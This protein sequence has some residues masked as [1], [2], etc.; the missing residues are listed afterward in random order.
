MVN[1]CYC[2]NFPELP[3]KGNYEPNMY[4]LYM[5]DT[6]LL[7]AMLDEEEQEDLRENKN[8][9]TYKGAIYENMIG[10]ALVKQGF[11]LYYYKRPD[12]KLEEAFPHFTAFLLKTYLK[13]AK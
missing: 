8:L 11:D 13:A 3:L 5:A 2:L 4:K 10:E 7:I 9:G 1:R 6:G 12:S